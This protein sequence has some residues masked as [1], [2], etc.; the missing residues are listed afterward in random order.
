M[1]VGTGGGPPAPLRSIVVAAGAAVDKCIAEVGAVWEVHRV[2]RDR[3]AAEPE[4]VRAAR[5]GRF[6]PDDWANGRE[7]KTK[8]D[9]GAERSCGAAVMR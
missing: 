9:Q 5:G 2:S 3:Y 7:R 4:P 1:T 6:G 8:P